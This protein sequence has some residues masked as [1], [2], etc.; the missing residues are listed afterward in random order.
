MFL[1]LFSDLIVKH[2]SEYVFSHVGTQ[3]S[4]PEGVNESCSLTRLFHSAFDEY[5]C[6]NGAFKYTT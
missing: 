6:A 1:L 4:L 5:N 2:P 3:T